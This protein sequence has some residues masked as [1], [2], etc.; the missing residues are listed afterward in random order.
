MNVFQL[1][2]LFN[3]LE[4]YFVKKH[5]FGQSIIGIISHFYF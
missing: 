3:G 5:V 2:L 1:I 4:K